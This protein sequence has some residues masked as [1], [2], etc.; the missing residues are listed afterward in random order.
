M[1]IGAT[2]QSAHQVYFPFDPSQGSLYGQGS[3]APPPIYG[4]GAGVMY[5]PS[6]GGSSKSSTGTGET[7]REAPASGGTSSSEAVGDSPAS[8]KENLQSGP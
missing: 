7:S 1:S 4:P 5:V 2:H 8:G 6:A 3:E